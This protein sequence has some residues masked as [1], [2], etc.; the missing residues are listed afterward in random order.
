MRVLLALALTML[1]VA[2]L[3]AAA[4]QTTDTLYIVGNTALKNAAKSG[5][6]TPA[7]PYIIE[8]LTLTATGA[9]GIAISDTNANAIL[10]GITVV[11]GG[12]KY[13]GIRLTNVSNIVIEGADLQFNRNGVA[14]VKANGTIVRDSSIRASQVGIL[15]EGTYKTQILRNE[16]AVNE[17]DVEFR[18]N[19]SLKWDARNN[20][21]RSNNLS[22]ATGQYG[23]FF[24]SPA[25]YDNDIDASNVVNFVAMRWHTNLRG[26]ATTP[27][28]IAD[29][30]VDVKGMTNVGQV[31]CY[32]CS[33]VR[34]D[35]VTGS[36][37]KASGLLIERSDNVTIS[38]A[39]AEGNEGAGIHV[40][41]ATRVSLDSSSAFQNRP[42]VHAYNTTWFNV[43]SLEASANYDQ[44]VVLT[45]GN[46]STIRQS[47]IKETAG[48]GLLF[49]RTNRSLAE[50]SSFDGNTGDGIRA[51]A[52][53]STTV[54]DASAGSNGGMGIHVTNS[55]FNASVLRSTA[56]ANRGGGIG[57]TGGALFARVEGNTLTANGEGGIYLSSAG[58]LNRVTD[59]DLAAQARH[60]RL[61]RSFQ[62]IFE[63][64]AMSGGG[65]ETGIWFDDEASYNNTIGTSNTV[66]GTPVQWHVAPAGSPNAPIVLSGIRVE[67]PNMTNI[68]Q[69]MIYKGSYLELRD[70]VAS[71][72]PRGVYTLRSSSLLIED[73][74]VANNGVGI[75][76]RGTQSGEVRDVRASGGNV[77][78]LLAETL[79][80]TVS[81]V[82]GPGARVAVID[83]DDKARSS[84]VDRTDATGAAR[85]VRDP[86]AASATPRHLIAD[87]G[88]DKLVRVGA[89][90]TFNDTIG[91]ARIGSERIV[92]QQW[93]FGDGELASTA[94]AAT[95]RPTHAYSA[96]GTYTARYELKTADGR[97]LRDTV[98]VR[99]V[100][101][102]QPPALMNMTADRENKT[103]VLNWS[104][105]ASEMPITTY[106][107][108]RGTNATNLTFLANSTTNGNISKESFDEAQTLW[109]A[110]SAVSFGGE[111]ELSEPMAFNIT[112]PRPPR[113][114]P[115]E[116]PEEPTPEA[117][118]EGEA[119]TPG[120][121]LLLV[122]AGIAAGALA[123]RRRRP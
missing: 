8:G 98:E 66:D 34:I 64:N 48:T 118:A 91:V 6:G 70:A 84:V 78:V 18:T 26:T 2:D 35:R 51:A 36:Y 76:L 97:T 85:S 50:A 42:G 67:T 59:N 92:R 33:H 5:A 79:N 103:V 52:A 11:A 83:I 77:S 19:A 20:T 13:D 63:S 107:I 90:V 116:E 41:N 15:F 23:F 120:P 27:R 24:G 110:V 69:V 75:D 60:I 9:H 28:T 95:L 119:D 46:N 101:P 99:V 14:L 30:L 43:T 113:P 121:G 104:V 82:S 73:V 111:S 3:P 44:G 74:D 123:M 94:D 37:G 40:R 56:D 12:D 105:P 108:Y 115:E 7:S 57:I 62:S 81:D 65:N 122:V 49:D 114:T 54:R 16:I 72:G 61:V 71:N 96:A 21:F 53:N 89:N 86:S 100:P 106:R 39:F 32:N 29:E 10:R 55:S 80:V 87:A 58:V 112:I 1:L 22:I 25:F 117:P 93:E 45:F 31:M 47:A 17:K 102:P 38:G 68:A 88:L 109:Y 4:A